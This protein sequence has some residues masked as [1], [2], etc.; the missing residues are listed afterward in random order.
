MTTHHLNP[1]DFPI[2]LSIKTDWSEMDIFGHINNVMFVKYV[3]A[4]RVNYWAQVGLM[5]DFE[6]LGLGPML[7][8]VS[9]N[10]YKPLFHPGEITI[11]AKMAFIKNSSFGFKHIILNADGEIA[12]EAHDVMVFY[13]FKNNHKIPFPQEVRLRV[14]ELEGREV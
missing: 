2:K 11:C 8:S 9:C 12:A 5:K 13:D 3:Q 7:A 6:S 1:A 10:F 4:S 14:K